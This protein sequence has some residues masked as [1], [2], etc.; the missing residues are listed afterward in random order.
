[1]ADIQVGYSKSA[2]KHFVKLPGNLVQE[3][4]PE[5]AAQIQE[6]PGVVSNMFGSALGATKEAIL[7]GA[8]MLLPGES[9]RALATQALQPVQQ[10]MQ[11]RAM[12]S[13]VSTLAGQ[14]IPNIAVDT[15]AFAAGGFPAAALIGAGMGAAQN[16]E[17]PL[18]GAAMGAA[19][20]AVPALPGMLA[21]G[22]R[23]VAP[24]MMDRVLGKVDD[25]TATPL[26][27]QRVGGQTIDEFTQN[28]EALGLKVPVSVRAQ[29]QT[30]E[31]IGSTMESSP[32]TAWAVGGAQRHNQQVLEASARKAAGLAPDAVMT[33]ESLRIAGDQAG[34]DFESFLDA[35]KAAMSKSDIKTL[36]EGS[37]DESFVNRGK[38]L[39][40]VDSLL[41]DFNGDSLTSVNL[42][43]LQ[44][45]IG[46]L[47]RKAKG[48]QSRNIGAAR[49]AIIER[50]APSQGSDPNLFRDAQRRWLAID[51]LK[52]A[53]GP[54]G[55]VSAARLAQRLSPSS[56][57]TE[58][59]NLAKVAESIS[60]MR[61]TS[62][63]TENARRG[64]LTGT[65]MT[66]A[67]GAAG[68]NFLF[69]N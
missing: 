19:G 41:N 21:A 24:R 25:V 42:H 47:E 40:K 32:L 52:K 39:K 8:S 62:Y 63:G 18:M 4:T 38:F 11:A 30:L 1:M 53:T 28:A 46:D 36:V 49:Q 58:L 59:S 55:E 26:Q 37:I 27:P 9:D 23:R 17:A 69:G 13:P 48:G 50:L 31:N 14:A 29:S 35:S 57:D 33:K 12:Q 20:G 60:Y 2:D 54:R 34:K 10:E 68:L 56:A 16:P 67:G 65:V 15:A 5:Q 45:A 64:G 7:G 61:P 3:V 66:G 22:A 44:S 51:A 6:N 43:K